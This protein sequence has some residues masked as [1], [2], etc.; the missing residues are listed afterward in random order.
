M[1]KSLTYFTVKL[2]S[3]YIIIL[4][5][6]IKAVVAAKAA[7]KLN[8]NGSVCQPKIRIN[9]QIFLRGNPGESWSLSMRIPNIQHLS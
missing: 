6:K 2:S 3:S 9:G 1:G 4:F 7:V 8:P 5:S